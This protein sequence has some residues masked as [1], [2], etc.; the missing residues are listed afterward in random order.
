MDFDDWSKLKEVEGIIKEDSFG[1]V[2]RWIGNE[3]QGLL[4]KA[5]SIW[6]IPWRAIIR[7]KKIREAIG[8]GKV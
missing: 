7:K 5:E 1:R 4:L 2:T 3:E 8:N 6:N